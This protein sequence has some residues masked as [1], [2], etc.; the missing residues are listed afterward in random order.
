[1]K[2]SDKIWKAIVAS[3]VVDKSTHD[4]EFKGANSAAVPGM[5]KNRKKIDKKMK[6]DV[7]SRLSSIL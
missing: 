1:M 6:F 4:P 3:T 2:C 7:S 5:E